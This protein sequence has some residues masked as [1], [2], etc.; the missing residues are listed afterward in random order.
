[1]QIGRESSPNCVQVEQEMHQRE[2]RH[3]SINKN[4]RV[5]PMDVVQNGDIP[6]RH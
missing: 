2:Y 4:L 6:N 1:M 3:A 5:V